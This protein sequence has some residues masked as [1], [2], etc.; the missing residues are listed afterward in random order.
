MNMYSPSSRSS[1]PNTEVAEIVVISATA[2]VIDSFLSKICLLSGYRQRGRTRTATRP[3]CRVDYALRCLA[4]R[5]PVLSLMNARIERPSMVRKASRAA[6]V[7]SPAIGLIF[8][9]T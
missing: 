9:T 8:F 5:P 2:S 3:A 7:I 6:S 4:L 1:C